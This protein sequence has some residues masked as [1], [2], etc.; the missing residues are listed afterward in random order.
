MKKIPRPRH[1][2]FSNLQLLEATRNVHALLINQAAEH[3]QQN[4]LKPN[5]K[6]IEY[7]VNKL[8]ADFEKFQIC[9]LLAI[10]RRI[11]LYKIIKHYTKLYRKRI[12]RA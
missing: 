4:E 12:S 11:P 8:L 1:I 3:L 6:S 10:E 7:R 9:L 2:K 5:F